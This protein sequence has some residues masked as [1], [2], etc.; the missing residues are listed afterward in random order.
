M[1]NQEVLGRTKGLLSMGGTERRENWPGGSRKAIS[2]GLKVPRQ[3]PL[4][5]LVG[6]K[7]HDQN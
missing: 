7:A 6:C 3:V 4:A 5:F 1:T 2:L